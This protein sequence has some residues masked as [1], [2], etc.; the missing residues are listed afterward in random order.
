MITRYDTQKL[1]RSACVMFSRLQRNRIVNIVGNNIKISP[2][3]IYVSKAILDNRA[4][5]N[6]YQ[7]KIR[8]NK[9]K[10]SR[11]LILAIKYLKISIIVKNSTTMIDAV[12]VKNFLNFNLPVKLLVEIKM[13]I[14]IPKNYIPKIMTRKI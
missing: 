4:N 12:N 1:F 9:V 14:K 8:R 5:L 6:L 2:K 3:L 11:V 7:G 13:I 10:I